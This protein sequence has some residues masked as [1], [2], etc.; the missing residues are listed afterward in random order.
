METMKA[1]QHA[2]RFGSVLDIIILSSLLFTHRRASLCAN[3]DFVASFL[4]IINFKQSYGF[5][6]TQGICSVPVSVLANR[7]STY[8]NL[9]ILK[10]TRLDWLCI[11]VNNPFVIVGELQ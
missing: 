3:I 1:E 8:I 9:L 11:N 7:P 5:F 10:Q 4:Q 6:F 2:C